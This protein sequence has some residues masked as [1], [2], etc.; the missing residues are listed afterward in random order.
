M[1]EI[2]HLALLVSESLD[3]PSAGL[4][5][6]HVRGEVTGLIK[7]GD[8]CI[9]VS[10][11]QSVIPK[12]GPLHDARLHHRLPEGWSQRRK[13]IQRRGAMMICRRNS[14]FRILRP[15]SNA[16]DF[17]VDLG[18]HEFHG[19][20]FVLGCFRCGKKRVS[21]LDQ[22]LRISAVRHRYVHL[23]LHLLPFEGITRRLNAD[24][25]RLAYNDVDVGVNLCRSSTPAKVGHVF[26]MHARLHPVRSVFPLES[27]ASS[28]DLNSNNDNSTMP[29]GTYSGII[30]CH[31]ASY[32]R[33]LIACLV[34]V[35][36]PLSS[37]SL[38][39]LFSLRFRC[40]SWSVLE[41]QPLR[42]LTR[43]V[44]P[45]PNFPPDIGRIAVRLR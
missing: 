28:T 43:I 12:Y 8:I 13:Q 41:V 36:N 3:G 29:S 1:T 24:L 37:T 17:A 6:L 45:A 10:R 20:F 16:I 25:R 40:V 34:G 14:T 44:E 9:A 7:D 21:R 15:V 31:I 18:W 38:E 19:D 4:W 22:M 42:P 33:I 35:L 5:K 26:S 39:H 30:T 11:T 23:S 2:T 27:L 32:I